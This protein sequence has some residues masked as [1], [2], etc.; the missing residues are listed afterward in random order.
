VAALPIEVDQ[1]MMNVIA[2]IFPAYLLLGS[3]INEAFQQ[4]RS[5]TSRKTPIND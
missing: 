5:V 2:I 3:Q 4:W 1:V